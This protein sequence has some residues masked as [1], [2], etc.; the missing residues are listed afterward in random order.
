MH[1]KLCNIYIGWEW[2]NFFVPYV[3]QLFSHL[4]LSY[5][6]LTVKMI[7]CTVLFL[8][9][10]MAIQ[11]FRQMMGIIFYQFVTS[12][13]TPC[14]PTSSQHGYCITIIHYCDITSLLYSSFMLLQY[15]VTI[16]SSRKLQVL[17]QSSCCLLF[18]WCMLYVNII[19]STQFTLC[20]FPKFQNSSYFSRCFW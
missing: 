19:S 17:L 11:N 9:A 10:Q 12:H 6:K 5:R 13:S 4:V 20:Y 16:V 1:A 18:R 7:A 14:Y 2:C 15:V 3:W 8:T